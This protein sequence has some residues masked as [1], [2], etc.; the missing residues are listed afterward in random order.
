MVMAACFR[1]NDF[2][3]LLTA[4]IDRRHREGLDLGLAETQILNGAV[5]DRISIGPVRRYRQRSQSARGCF[6]RGQA[7]CPGL[8]SLIGM[9]P[10]AVRNGKV[11]SSVT[12]LLLGKPTTADE[13]AKE[14]PPR[15]I[16]RSD[17]VRSIRCF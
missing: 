14:L 11:V 5:G 12:S 15:K 8:A 1:K 10:T 2:A 3:V 9:N 16:D 6:H 7:A 4:T 13:F 17:G